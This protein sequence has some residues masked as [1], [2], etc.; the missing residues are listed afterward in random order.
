MTYGRVRVAQDNLYRDGA[1]VSHSAEL[2]RGDLLTCGTEGP[3]IRP[4]GPF[5]P[6]GEGVLAASYCKSKNASNTT[7]SLLLLRW[8]GF[9]RLGGAA[10]VFPGLEAAEDVGDGLEAHV[11]RRLGGQRGA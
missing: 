4:S 2:V 9:A 6:R 10:G 7:V 11:L 1:A 5:S 8:L 3:L